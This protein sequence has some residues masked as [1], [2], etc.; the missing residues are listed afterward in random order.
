MQVAASRGPAQANRRSPL[1]K[2][3]QQQA[4]SFCR[5]FARVVLPIADID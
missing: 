1:E 2:A 3:A 5:S 4:T